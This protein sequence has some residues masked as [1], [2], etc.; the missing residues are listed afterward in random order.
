MASATGDGAPLAPPPPP[1]HYQQAPVYQTPD[2]EAHT[3]SPR[4]SFLSRFLPSAAAATLLARGRDE[5]HTAGHHDLEAS[6]KEANAPGAQGN[7]NGAAPRSVESTLPAAA[8]ASTGAMTGQSPSMRQRL[9][10]ILPPHRTY[11]G[12][13]R[14]FILLYVLLPLAILLFIILPLAIGLGVGLSRR[15]GVDSS[16]LPLPSNT[17]T[18]TGDLT[19]YDPGLGACGVTSTSNDDIVS[20]SHIIFD[21]ASTG[22][23]PNANRLCG[24]KIR[25]ERANGSGGN[26]SVDVTVVDRCT[27]C[28]AADLD[29]T[30]AVFTQLAQEEEGRVQMSWAWL[31]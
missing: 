26:N 31:S 16:S 21:A 22:S 11:F 9:D 3:R 30:L 24:Q 15:N 5:N 17:A 20:V 19:F 25:I 2:W 18:F 23:N 28:A 8:A 27:G 13:S 14:R 12:R 1:P 6:T 10:S 4:H 29:V 7:G